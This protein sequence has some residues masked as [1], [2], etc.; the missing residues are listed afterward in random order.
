[1][2]WS[3]SSRSAWATRYDAI[4]QPRRLLAGVDRAHEDVDGPALVVRRALH[5]PVVT[6]P[7]GEPAE[8]QVAE[9]RRAGR[10]RTAAARGVSPPRPGCWAARSQAGSSTT[11][12]NAARL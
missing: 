6:P 2:T 1:M 4:A 10:V 12:L 5:V 11:Q 9:R 7:G 8:R 3:M